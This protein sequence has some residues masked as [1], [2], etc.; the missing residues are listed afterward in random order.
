[1]CD[2]TSDLVEGANL[3]RTPDCSFM[4]EIGLFNFFKIHMVNLALRLLQ[5]RKY[6]AWNITTTLKACNNIKHFCSAISANVVA[7]ASM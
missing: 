4:Q 7:C 1:M 6:L 2:G 3:E 5:D